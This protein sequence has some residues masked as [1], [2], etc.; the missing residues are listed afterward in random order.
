M[1]TGYIVAVLGV[2]G[3]IL[4]AGMYAAKYHKTIG[5][6]GIVI[7]IVLI[8]IGIWMARGMKPQTQAQPSPAAAAK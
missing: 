3:L 1:K 5:L 8:L 2:L 6:G 4:G 7:G